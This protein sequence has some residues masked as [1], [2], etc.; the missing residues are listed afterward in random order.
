[1][2]LHHDLDKYRI[3]NTP[4]G[5]SSG[6]AHGM[7]VIPFGSNVL[8]V[9]SSGHG[10]P[11]WEHVSVSLQNRCPNWLEMCFIKSMFWGEDERVVQFHPP[12]NEYVNNHPFCLHLW[13]YLKGEMP[14]PEWFLVGFKEEAS[15][16]GK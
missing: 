8:R 16:D 12:A 4:F 3:V 6:E 14:H 2:K 15:G 13:K 9:V 10:D 1:M 7:F 5:T 11:E